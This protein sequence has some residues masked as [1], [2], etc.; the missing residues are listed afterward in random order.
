MA[1]FGIVGLI[2]IV[3]GISVFVQ[4]SSISSSTSQMTYTQVPTAVESARLT[5][6]INA[7]MASLRG[8]VLTGDPGFKQERATDWIEIDRARSA[9]DQLAG[10]WTSDEERSDWAEFQQVLEKFKAA[11]AEVEN[12]AH[13]PAQFPA[14]QVLVEEAA[15]LAKTM[16]QEIS[17]I[18]NEEVDIR[19]TPERRRLFAAMGDIRA[20]FALSTANIRAFLLSGEAKFKAQFDGVWPWMAG[21][22]KSLEEHSYMLST[23]QLESLA[24]FRKAFN[25]FAP[26]APRMFEIR[27]S[28]K[29]NMAQYLLRTGPAKLATPLIEYLNGTLGADGVRTGGLVN[30]NQEGLE[31]QAGETVDKISNLNSIV[32]VLMIGGLVFVLF[33]A[34]LSARSIV[35]PVM[36]MTQAMKQLAEGNLESTIPA[37]NRRDEIGE[38]A[39]AMQV[40]KV[41]ES[42]R[43]RSEEESRALQSKSE[44]KANLQ[45]EYSDKFDSDVSDVLTV[46]TQAAESVQTNAEAMLNEARHTD[47]LSAS[48]AAASDEA[49]QNV[50]T[51]AAAT[52][53]LSVSVR[54]IQ[55]QVGDSTQMA[56]AAANGAQET[57]QEIATLAESAEKI[58]T[59]VSLIKEI[60]EQ[61]NLLALNATIEAAR[62][63][64]AGKGFAVVASEVK[65]L[66]SQTARATEEISAQVDDIQSAT[67][68]AVTSIGGIA[69]TIGNL[70]TIAQDISAAVQEQNDATIEIARSI[71]QAASGTQRVSGDISE[72]RQASTAT[73]SAAQEVLSATEELTA[74]S[75]TLRSR[76]E[77]FLADMRTA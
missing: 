41:N 62:A 19:P 54:E 38:M 34:R 33:V 50:A 69:A 12:I 5:T 31:N 52:E 37:L 15:P 58:G 28:E 32:W 1:G 11:Q 44:G 55:R 42:S 8:W 66:A 13:T 6:Y 21:Q 22:F 16:L 47:E 3:M 73:G 7:S 40:F 14:T 20:G 64:E 23:S 45:N 65:N 39:Q 18:L 61:T 71:E 48:V 53:Q 25:A 68:G 72:V 17:F 9:I 36:S 67:S 27:Q 10:T 46:F 76:V 4:V 35:T 56:S 30:T 60:A 70:D 63:G 29:W 2:V 43:R 26:L 49:A 51:V 77:K 59:V 24:S 74:R 75:A 57:R